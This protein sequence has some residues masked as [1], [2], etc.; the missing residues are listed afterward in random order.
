MQSQNHRILLNHCVK[1]HLLDGDLC[2]EYP[3]FLVKSS[4]QG[5]DNNT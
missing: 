5:F 2:V 4:L 3:S 1:K